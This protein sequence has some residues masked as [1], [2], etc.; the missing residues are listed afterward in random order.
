MCQGE[1]GPRYHL[2]LTPVGQ[3]P[4]RF[5]R[6]LLP[7]LIALPEPDGGQP[8]PY[9]R[10][11][12]PTGITNRGVRQNPDSYRDYQSRRSTKT[13][14]VP[15]QERPIFSI[16]CSSV[17]PNSSICGFPL[18]MT[19][20]AACTTAGSTQPPLTEPE[21]SPFSLTASFAPGLRGAEPAMLTTVAT[22][23]FSPSARHFSISGNTSRM[24]LFPFVQGE[25]T[26]FSYR[27]NC[28]TVSSCS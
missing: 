16:F 22:A 6:T 14:I 7:S 20:I 26:G 27:P 23:T 9:S 18:F 28:P 4:I 24:G 11:L 1:K 15:P 5:P 17:M 19:S 3:A 13:W 8:H 12:I 25:D 10:I 2:T 21:S